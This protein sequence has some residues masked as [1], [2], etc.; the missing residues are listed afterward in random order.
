M[1]KTRA[2]L[3]TF[4]LCAFPAAA[5]AGNGPSA[6]IPTLGEAGLITLAAVLAVGGVIVVARRKR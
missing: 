4:V 3:W 6:V 1:S 5:F 2:A